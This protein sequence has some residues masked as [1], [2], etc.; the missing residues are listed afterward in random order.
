LAIFSIIIPH[1]SDLGKPQEV[2]VDGK[3]ISFNALEEV[4][5]N[6][7]EKLVAENENGFTSA[8][9]PAMRFADCTPVQSDALAR[10]QVRF[11]VAL[12][13]FSPNL[14]GYDDDG[15]GVIVDDIIGVHINHSTGILTLNMNDLEVNEIF[16][17]LVTKLEITV[18]LKKGGWN[19]EVLVVTPDQATGLFS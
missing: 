10:N 7:F 18:Y 16:Q 5:L 1:L 3:R 19:N 9:F 14:D 6:I 17:T 4:V 2:T 12:Q 11:A 8:G 15:Y 13:A